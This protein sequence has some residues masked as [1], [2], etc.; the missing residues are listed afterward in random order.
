MFPEWGSLNTKRIHFHVFFFVSGAY[1]EGFRFCQR[2]LHEWRLLTKTSEGTYCPVDDA[3]M[4]ALYASKYATKVMHHRR[5]MSSHFGW[6]QYEVAFAC[7]AHGIRFQEVDGK[8]EAGYHRKDIKGGVKQWHV[9]VE[10]VPVEF[11][12]GGRDVVGALSTYKAGLSVLGSVELHE[13]SH[14]IYK[15]GFFKMRG[16]RRLHV[17]RTSAVSTTISSRLLSETGTVT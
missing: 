8:T 13:A 12:G 1:W 14:T 2:F 15:G 16:E 4:A 17:E 6:A 7:D 5:T 3:E 9:I 10:H 11:V